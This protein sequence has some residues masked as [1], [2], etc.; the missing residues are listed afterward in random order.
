[1]KAELL[2]L[3]GKY[4]GTVIRITG[5]DG[6]THI[7]KLWQCG[8]WVPSDRECAAAGITIDQWQANANVTLDNGETWPAK[9]LLEI[10]DSHFESRETHAMAEQI[11]RCLTSTDSG[12]N[13]NG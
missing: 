4:Y 13:V 2:P 9:E 12:E 3:D 1:M 5:D 10:C 6:Y 8:S 11:V 7:I